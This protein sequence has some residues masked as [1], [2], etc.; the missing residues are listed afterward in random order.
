MIMSMV[1]LYI[2]KRRLPV[3]GAHFDVLMVGGGFSGTMLAVH[4]LR[5]SSSLSVADRRPWD[6]LPGEASPTAALTDF[7]S[8]T[9]P[10]VR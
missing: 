3:D 6:A 1:V 8:L 5:N 9:Y 10:R 2:G 4:L 7:T